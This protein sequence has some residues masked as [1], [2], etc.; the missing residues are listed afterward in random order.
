MLKKIFHIIFGLFLLILVGR[1]LQYAYRTYV[2]FRFPEPDR[3]GIIDVCQSNPSFSNI[4]SEYL[5]KYLKIG[6]I[7]KK[8]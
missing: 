7:C 2:E 8:P 4:E 3:I 5:Y 6:K 1:S